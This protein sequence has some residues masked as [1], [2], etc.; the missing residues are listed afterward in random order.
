MRKN[1]F[2][3]TPR[4]KLFSSESGI[5][6]RTLICQD[7]GTQV[8]SAEHPSHMRCPNCGGLRMRIK[9]IPYSEPGTP[10]PVRTEERKFSIFLTPYEKSLK[11]FSGKTMTRDEFEKTFSDKSEYMLERGFANVQGDNV[12]VSE[13]AFEG[14]R[15]FSKLIIQVTK[16]MDL[17]EDI[18]R[19]DYPKEDLIEHMAGS[20]RMP[21]KE[22]VI[23][24]K[25]HGLV[26]REEVFC[27]PEKDSWV[28]D[29]SIIPDLKL[30]Y[31]NQSFGIKQFMEI[32]NNRYPDAPDN[33]IDILEKSGTIILDGSQVTVNK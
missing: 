23:L 3:S 13:T 33:I 18:V 24:K 30:E 16:I 21:P 11:E 6:L 28:E 9:F 29:S 20:F 14:E 31:G 19:G 17:D 12:E 25:A 27:D 22:I 7:C 10:E 1:I 26:P 15:F 4:K 8:E 5:K 2:K 32:L